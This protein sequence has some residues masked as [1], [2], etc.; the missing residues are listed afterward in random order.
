MTHAAGYT[1]AA[2]SVRAADKEKAAKIAGELQA[3][4]AAL[5]KLSG[6]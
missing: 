6:S 2:D 3:V 1:K 5:A 4:E